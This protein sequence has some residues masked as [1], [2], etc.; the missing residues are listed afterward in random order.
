M[1]TMSSVTPISCSGGERQRVAI[2]RALVAGPDL[3]LCDEVLS[4]LDVSVQA[5]VLC[6]AG[7][8]AAGA[9]PRHAV[10]LARPGRRAQPGPTGSAYSFR[11]H[12]M[13]VGGVDAVFAPPFHPYNPQPADG[14]ARRARQAA[15]PL[16]QAACR[17]AAAGRDRLRFRRP[18][19]L[20][21]GQDLRRAGTALAGS[22]QRAPNP[23][24]ILPLEE[25]DRR[26]VWRPAGATACEPSQD[27]REQAISFLST[28][29]G[30][31][32]SEFSHEHCSSHPRHR[33]R[34]M[35]RRLGR[36]RPGAAAAKVRSSSIC[37]R[38]GGDCACS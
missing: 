35:H 15:S 8:A 21:G 24:P 38:I 23:L 32:Q 13:E 3:L 9:Q 25:L 18:L 22:I 11:G 31:T 2:A 37:R 1:P 4:A 29:G 5:S 19:P 20:A 36:R 14:R 26:A 6:V 34:R 30:R 17:H 7:G 12:L 33:R 10:H 27:L 16:R 28:R